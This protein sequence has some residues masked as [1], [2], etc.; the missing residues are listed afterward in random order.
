MKKEEYQRVAGELEKKLNEFSHHVD[1]LHGIQPYE[2][3][4]C[5][6]DQLI[7]SIRRIQYVD[8]IRSRPQHAIRND[9]TSD[10]FDPLRA[11]SYLSS[12]G[13]FEEACWVTFLAT[14][15]G[16][17]I[18]T[19]W[20]L[21][22][23]LYGRDRPTGAWTWSQVKA[24]PQ[25]YST[26]AARAHTDFVGQFGNHRKYESVKATGN[27]PGAVVGSYVAWVTAAG[28]HKALFANALAGGATP[29]QAFGRLYREMARVHRFGRTGRFDYLTM[30]AKLG[31]AAIDADATY[32]RNATGPLRGARLLFSGQI[33][34]QLSATE[35]EARLVVLEAHLN[36]GMQVLE[37]SLCNWQKSPGRY[38]YFGG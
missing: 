1:R 6:V 13:E 20:T 37:D 24:N 27:G 8:L 36:T 23:E 9:P 29:R 3:L 7:D 11:A 28:S 16:K 2:N 31:L 17:N 5:F 32:M 38:E 21:A 30:L 26:W 4:Q 18:R 12:K 25:A 15:A 14:H 35:L 22:A 19:G 33:D 10:I 34:A